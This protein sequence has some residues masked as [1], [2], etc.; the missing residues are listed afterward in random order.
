M[1]IQN[2]TIQLKNNVN[3]TYIEVQQNL[4]T[5]EIFQLLQREKEVPLE[6]K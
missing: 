4:K 2:E 1:I 3:I 6:K 5:E